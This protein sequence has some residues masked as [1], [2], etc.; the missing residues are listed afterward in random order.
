MQHTIRKIKVTAYS[1][2][3]ANERPLAFILDGK[4]LEVKD[5]VDRWYGQDHDYFKVVASDGK[6]YLIKWNR[7]LDVWLLVDIFERVGRH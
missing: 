1:S 5:I 3:K 6:I 4:K 7:S 2:Y